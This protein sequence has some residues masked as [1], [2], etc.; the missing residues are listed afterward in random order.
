M[1]MIP[2]AE[3][4]PDRS[5]FDPA[6]SD[7]ILNAVPTADGWG[8]MKG[9]ELISDALPA[10][11]R[12][13]VFVRDQTGS[14]FIIAGTASGLYRFDN[15]DGSWDDISGASAPYGVADGDRWSF[16]VY[17]SKLVATNIA[18][19]VQVYDIDAGGA[20]ADLA[21][22]PPQARHAFVANGYL[23]LGNTNGS[24]RRVQWSGYEDI[25]EWT[26]GEK[27]ADYQDLPDGGDVAG[28]IG[29]EAGA[30]VF[31]RDRVRRMQFAPASQFSFAFQ[32]VDNARGAVS[33][34]SIVPIGLNDFAFLSESGF[35][36]GANATP[37]GAEKVDRWFY[38]T[39]D[40]D[41]LAEVQGVADPFNK[42]V[43]WLFTAADATRQMVGYDWQV[44][45]WT[46]SD[47]NP[48]LLAGLAAPAYTLEALDNVDGSIDALPYSLDSR[49]WSG[50]RPAFAAFDAA[51]RLG[52]F[53]GA[54]LAA[55]LETA[56]VTLSPGYRSFVSGLRAI[57]DADALTA[58]AGRKDSES[59]ALSWGNAAAPSGVTGLVALRSSA[60]LHRFRLDIAAGDVWSVCHGVEP[61]AR[62]EGR[63]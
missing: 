43:W 45:R 41:F 21:G 54:A 31:Q 46:R 49:V 53:E 7:A 59:G 48:T 27:G 50:G 3:F 61:E 52:F 12:G 17:G 5:R 34:L 19:P 58:R 10:T 18:D 22:S 60:R 42:I 44:D 38:D 1:P 20:F 25:E 8:P 4:A 2:I 57:T 63:R 40:L 6:S 14:F 15:A 11:A 36:R 56:D 16:A 28:G 39:V 37:I 13:A 9:L 33:P 55:T 32:E 26:V 29:D 47:A 23:V 24:A 51:D 30:Y 35:Y 62:R